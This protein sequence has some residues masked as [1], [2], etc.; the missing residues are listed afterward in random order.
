MNCVGEQSDRS[1]MRQC[2]FI[3]DCQSSTAPSKR[4][5]KKIREQHSFGISRASRTIFCWRYWR[6]SIKSY[7]HAIEL[8]LCLLKE[9]PKVL[10]C[11]WCEPMPMKPP[12]ST[13]ADYR[14]LGCAKSRT[15]RQ[16]T[17]KMS[18]V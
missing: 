8:V 13:R 14:G 15:C 2:I 18:L 3:W 7:R 6:G 10:P 12:K 1:L 9:S 16:L 11:I 17:W 5:S 4:H